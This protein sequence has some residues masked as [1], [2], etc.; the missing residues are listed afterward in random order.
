MTTAAEFISSAHD[1]LGL[2]CVL[3]IQRVLLCQ[4][5]LSQRRDATRGWRV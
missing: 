1:L 4:R 2:F 3:K 5:G